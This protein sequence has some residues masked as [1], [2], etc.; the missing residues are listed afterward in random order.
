VDLYAALKFLH[1]LLA[2]VAVGTN[3]TYGVWVSRA[4]RDPRHLAFAL[5]GIK[6]L[7]DRMANPAYGLLLVTGLGMVHFG[8]IAWTTPWLLTSLVLYGAVVVLGLLGFT[9]VLRRQIEVL[10]GRGADS[11]EY[12][13]LAGQA[14]M[15]GMLL[16]ILV[17]LI[18]L[19]MVIKP[20]LW[21]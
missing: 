6:V 13:A 3:V 5:R 1:V 9:P 8:T 10:E 18:V 16:A 14:R 19:L 15:I 7:D 12:R 21:S 11:L 20:V 2:I 17:A 4:S